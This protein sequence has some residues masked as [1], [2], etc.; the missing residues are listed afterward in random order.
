MPDRMVVRAAIHPGIGI[1][2]V[3]NSPDEFFVGPEL[4]Y[5]SG[6]PD[7]G[8][9]DPAGALKRQAARFRI[10]GYDAAGEIVGE[11]TADDASISWSVHL[12]NKK[13]AWYNFEVALDIANTMPCTRRNP[14]FV[15][16][17]R[18]QLV[19]DPG[20]RRISGRNR[21]GRAA[22][23]DTGTF[24]GQPVYLGELH[25]DRQGRLLVLGG[26]GHAASAF[27]HN[28]PTTFA[29]NLGWHDDTSDG[30][31]EATVQINGRTIPVDPAWVVVAPPNY[32]PDIISVQT[33]YDV[34]FDTYQDQW[35]ALGQTPSF[36]RDIAPLLMRFCEQQWVNYGFFVQFGRGGPNEFVRADYLD[37]LASARPEYAE[38]R[39]QIFHMFRNPASQVLDIEGWPPMYGDD[40][41]GPATDPRQL[42]SIT[43]TQYGYLKQWAAGTFVA[44]WEQRDRSPA[45][46]IED[47]P[48]AQQPGVLD[49][50]A[51]TFCLGGPFH[52]GC[53]LTWPMR[54]ITLYRAPFRIR[55]RSANQPEP[56][57]GEI[58]TT[59]IVTSAGGPLTA[60][61]PGDLTRWMAVPWHTDTASCQAGYTAAYEPFLPTFWPARVPNHVLREHE[62]QHLIDKNLPTEERLLAFQTRMSWPRSLPPVYLD[63]I[64]AM[65]D[66]FDQ[67][68]VVERRDGPA[69][70][71]EIPPDVYV[72]AEIG[73]TDSPDHE[74]VQRQQV[75]IGADQLRRER[76][77]T[78]NNAIQ[79]RS[80]R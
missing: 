3:G 4:P 30:P 80:K 32:A 33:M 21:H 2:R 40:V 63:T 74:V 10:Y 54:S 50:A 41:S 1:A 35:F 25:T 18:Q 11:L 51:L 7:G 39:R 66:H 42:L 58:L 60:S 6:A 20:P 73:F 79:P 22:I 31:V 76:H 52:P 45:Q 5:P 71:P 68:G 65:V 43:A 75:R 23:F 17:Q 64:R 36:T 49:Q 13:A 47:V 57:Y 61:S 72:E 56:D 46:R 16:E 28:P 62:Y 48:I 27:P 14:G 34:L 12:A 8:Y 44:D 77:G 37:R 67:L 53:E 9:K 15:G 70:L 78:I 29:N 26:H 24:C 69:D 19:I 38:L 59:A 55:P